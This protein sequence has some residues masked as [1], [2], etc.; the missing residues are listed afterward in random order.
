MSIPDV[1]KLCIL[2]RYIQTIQNEFSTSH[3]Q[4]QLSWY[5]GSF[6]LD[7]TIKLFF[8]ILVPLQV[9]SSKD[10]QTIIATRIYSIKQVMLSVFFE[11]SIRYQFSRIVKCWHRWFWAILY[12]KQMT[13]NLIF[14]LWQNKSNT[15]GINRIN[16]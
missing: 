12:K 16:R 6:E 4:F 15:T 11:N 9:T 14:Q 13:N 10:N 3:L 2:Y 7:R 1:Y 8:F 5:T